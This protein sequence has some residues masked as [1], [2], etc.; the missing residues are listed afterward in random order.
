VNICKAVVAELS[1]EDKADLAAAGVMAPATGM[2]GRVPDDVTCRR[3][4]TCFDVS[5]E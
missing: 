2:F 3:C 1:E 5:Q 4:H